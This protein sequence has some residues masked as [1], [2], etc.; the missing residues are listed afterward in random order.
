MNLFIT[1]GCYLKFRTVRD[2]REE[3]KRAAEKIV[4]REKKLS[5][6]RNIWES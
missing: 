4:E 1:L 2:R 3:E 5:R 6:W